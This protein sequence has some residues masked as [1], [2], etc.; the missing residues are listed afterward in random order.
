MSGRAALRVGDQVR[1]DERLHTV[2][3]L[4]GTLVR[5]A[6][7]AG[8]ASLVLLPHLLAAEGFEFLGQRD[9]SPVVAPFA[10][11]DTVPP[12]EAEKATAWEQHLLELESGRQS[13]IG[14][15]AGPRPEYD[16]AR[17]TLEERIAA[18]A[19]ELRALGWTVSARTVERMRTRYRDQGV[20]GLVDHRKTRLSSPTGRADERVVAAVADV[21]AAQVED[22]T[23]TRGRVRR[24]VEALLTE[25]H[26]AGVVRMPSKSAFYRLVEAVSTGTHA[27]GSASSRRSQARRPA[28]AF[29]PSAACRPGE[30]VQSTRLRWMCW[31]SWRT[32]S[33]AVPS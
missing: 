25:R 1:L 28:G 12:L 33:A 16:P 15:G 21:L 32:G 7:E 29:T 26:G 5:L 30:L 19:T 20:W 14:A 18:K 11:L 2:V 31:W 17:H 22:S 13:G 27:F 24:R 23:G 6:D 10:L 4:S 9:G 3:G 8:R